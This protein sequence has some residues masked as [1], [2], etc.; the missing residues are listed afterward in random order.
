MPAIRNMSIKYKLIS[1]TMATCIAALLTA[2]VVFIGWEWISLRKA[3]VQNLSTQAEIIAD[4]CRASVAF[5][6]SKDAAE[7]LR[8]LHVDNSIVFGCIYTPD[9]NEFTSFY[10]D[11][12]DTRV[13]PPEIKDTGH[14]F[15]SN[16]FLVSTKSHLDIL[17]I[18]L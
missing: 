5:K 4:N 12:A 11:F 7:I 13:R 17:C 10:R 1:I 3:T 6:D 15:S 2:G 9:Q 8:A 16:I 18:L 14:Y